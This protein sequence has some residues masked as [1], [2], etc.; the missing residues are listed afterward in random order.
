[1][2]RIIQV[3]SLLIVLGMLSSMFACSSGEGIL[4][5]QERLKVATT[6][7]LYDTGLWALLE[8]KFED[9]YDVELDVLY[10]NTGIAIEYGK[11]GD[12]DALAVHDKARELTFISE[13][14][15]TTRNPFAYNYFVIAGPA[16]DPLGLKDL[17]P[18]E[19]FKKLA[20][21]KTAKFISRG[22][23][24][25]T[26]SKEKAIWKAAGFTYADIQKSGDWYVEAGRGM[27]PTLIMAGEMQGYTLSDIGT[28]LAFKSDTGL[29]S[30]VQKGSIMLNVYSVIPVNPEKITTV[31]YDLAQKLVDF[32]VSD[33][34]QKMIGEYGVKD[35]GQS[36][37][38]PC[39]GNEP[40]P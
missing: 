22:D 17:S 16:S 9:K 38:T 33:E 26:H 29:V 34:V 8:P 3:V 32:M 40:I 5:P 1:L 21:S 14:Y 2:K 19:A 12:V 11:R 10:A 13:G 18:E 37:F 39:A 6:S 30:I 7:S 25:G 23:D 4:K 35:Y 27:G 36:L 20:E 31:K 28:F 24:S 15:G